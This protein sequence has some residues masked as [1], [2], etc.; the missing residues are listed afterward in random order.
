MWLAEFL[1][2]REFGNFMVCDKTLCHCLKDSL[3]EKKIYWFP[4]TTAVSSYRYKAFLWMYKD[5]LD[6]H[7]HISTRGSTCIRTL[8]RPQ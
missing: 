6:M 2:V 1:E 5:H 4:F 3:S 8:V 7:F